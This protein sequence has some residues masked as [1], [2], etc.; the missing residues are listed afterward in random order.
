LNITQGLRNYSKPIVNPLDV[1]FNPC[2][3]LVQG[4][5]LAQDD[6]RCAI[7]L[8]WYVEARPMALSNRPPFRPYGHFLWR[9]LEAL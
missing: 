4:L 3:K 5:M 7:E 6:H 1:D 2:P 9:E 8:L